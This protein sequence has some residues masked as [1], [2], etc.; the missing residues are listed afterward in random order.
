MLN[1]SRDPAAQPTKSRAAQLRSPPLGPSWPSTYPPA[2]PRR[3]LSLRLADG[4]GPV[5]IPDLRP[6]PEPEPPARVAPWL[7]AAFPA[8]TRYPGTWARASGP[9]CPFIARR[10]T[11]APN[12]S[13]TAP[14]PNPR[15]R[16]RHRTPSAPSL[17]RRGTVQELRVEVRR[18]AVP[19]VDAPMP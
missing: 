1:Q 2:Q 14:P 4:W 11:E 19:L 18:L 17:L 5:V 13:Y 16:Y 8:P 10:R 6:D 3:L 7:C 15:R 12:P 9:P